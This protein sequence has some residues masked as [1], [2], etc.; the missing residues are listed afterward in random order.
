M[1]PKA[2]YAEI[3]AKHRDQNRED[4]TPHQ[5]REAVRRYVIE[6]AL[7]HAIVDVPTDVAWYTYLDDLL[8][9]A[10]ATEIAAAGGRVP[11]PPPQYRWR[12][13]CDKCLDRAEARL[14]VLKDKALRSTVPLE[15]EMGEFV[16][17]VQ[18]DVR[19]PEEG[20]FDLP[21]KFKPQGKF[22]G[23]L[24]RTLGLP[25]VRFWCHRREGDKYLLSPV[26]ADDF[27]QY[28]TPHR[29]WFQGDVPEHVELVDK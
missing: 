19:P 21:T 22:L 2:L 7:G 13:V 29:C 16:L 14:E 10:L 4:P 12:C 11:M 20:D 18:V 3:A 1:Y 24:H 25:K 17:P 27:W 9:L 5:L 28:R 8:P 23:W 15:N 26:Q 6:Q